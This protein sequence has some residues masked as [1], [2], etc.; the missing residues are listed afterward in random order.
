MKIVQL[1]AE[2]VKRIKAVEITPDGNLVEI[3]GGND[4]GKSSIMDSIWMALKWAAAG[5]E[6]I[7]PVRDGENHARV[8]LDLGDLVVTRTWANGKTSL[9][10]ESA[11]GTPQQRPQE[12]LDNLVGKLSFDPLAFAQQDDKTQV[13]TLLALVDVPLDLESFE[14]KRQQH[15]DKRHLVGQDVTRAKGAWESMPA[16]ASNGLPYEDLPAEPVPV[17]ALATEYQ[18]AVRQATAYDN[19]NAHMSRCDDEV[20][21]LE[22]ALEA[23]K[24]NQAH[25]I[26]AMTTHRDRDAIQADVDHLKTQ[27]DEAEATNQAIREGQDYYRLK[28]AWEA[29]KAEWDELDEAIKHLDQ[30]KADALAA[31]KFPIKGLGFDDT[32]VTFNGVPFSQ[33]SSSQRIKVSMAIAMATNPQ[34]RV[35][36]I[37]DGSLLDHKNMAVIEKM[38]KDKDFQVWIER[39]DA[40]A[41]S[42]VVIEDGK[43]V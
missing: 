37:M 1:T 8:R 4:E 9:L 25:A 31:A 38:A 26:Q 40:N 21:R 42:G 39:V 11:D 3:T 35:I 43:V 7:R 15:Y 32:G 28:A 19:A 22:E 14:Q 27:M 13:K 24:Q 5:K 34:L 29:K 16:L 30:T 23:A 12:L 20:A 36:R 41:K 17:S 2:N 18:E 10:V 33:A 6:T